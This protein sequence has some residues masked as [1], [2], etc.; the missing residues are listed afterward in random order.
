MSDISF[1]IDCGPGG[2]CSVVFRNAQWFTPGKAE[3]SG[4]MLLWKKI[5]KAFESVS[6]SHGGDVI[7]DFCSPAE[8]ELALYKSGY[9]VFDVEGKPSDE[10]IR[11]MLAAAPVSGDI[12]F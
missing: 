5:G 2:K 7:P 1:H 11:R 3:A 6:A 9:P 4:D 12:I 10:E 8:F